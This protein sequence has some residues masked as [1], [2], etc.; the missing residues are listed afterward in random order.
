MDKEF[1]MEKVNK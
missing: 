1:P